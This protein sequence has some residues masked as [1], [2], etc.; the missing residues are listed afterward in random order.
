MSRTLTSNEIED[1]LGIFDDFYLGLDKFTRRILID[2]IK[3]PLRLQLAKVKIDPE[4]IYKLRGELARIYR[5]VE[6][7]KSIGI[8]TAQSV[9]EMQ[10]QMNLNVFHRAGYRD[11]QVERSSRLQELICTSKTETQ[12]SLMCSVYFIP[13]FTSRENMLR[14]LTHK[15][16]LSYVIDYSASA[17]RREWED[18]YDD[19]YKPNLEY[20]IKIRYKLDL[21]LLYRYK[22]DLCSI[23]RRLKDLVEGIEV[24][25]SPLY[26]GEVCVYSDLD[27][28]RALLNT[29]LHGVEAVKQAYFLPKSLGSA[30]LF[31]ETEGSNLKEILYLPFVDS[32]NTITND[33]WEVYDLFGIEAVR[34]FLVE[35][36]QTI[37]PA[38]HFSHIDFLSDRMTVSGHLKSITRYTRKT[39]HRASVLSKITFEETIKRATD[40]AF[41]EQVDNV[42]GCSASV[43]VGKLP[44]V[45]AGMNELYFEYDI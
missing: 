11:Q 25:F 12:G 35:E 4:M 17:D 1:V 28:S 37:M 5:Q 27:K 23:A 38:V 42:K 20:K 6:A 34:Q 22:L 14:S 29:I 18:K 7:G 36:F 13:D 30:D 45:G 8:I 31:I 10:T 16:F 15:S 3:A 32:Y 24:T 40:A 39:E 19:F 43:I 44:S 41:A 26:I 9:G 2:D 33:I 21:D